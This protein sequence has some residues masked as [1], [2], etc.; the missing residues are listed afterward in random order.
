MRYFNFF[1]VRLKTSSPLLLTYD[2]SVKHPSNRTVKFADRTAVVGLIAHNNES[3]LQAGGGTTRANNPCTNVKK[4]KEM[5]VDFRKGG[6][7]PLPPLYRR[8][9]CCRQPHLERQHSQQSRG[10]PPLL[11]EEAEANFILQVWWWRV[12][13]LLCCRE[14]GTAAGG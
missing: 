6:N 1:Y 8:S 3:P 7:T 2:C 5:I 14:K 12:S 10:G 11:P 4:T 9:S 13:S